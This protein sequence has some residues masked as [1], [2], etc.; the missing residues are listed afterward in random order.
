MYLSLLTIIRIY[1]HPYLV[2]WLVLPHNNPD[3]FNFLTCIRTL[4]LSTMIRISPIQ[5]STYPLTCYSSQWS[6]SIYFSSVPCLRTCISHDPNL[7]LQPKD[8]FLLTTIRIYFHPYLVY[9]LVSPNNNP[10]MSC[11]A[12]PCLL[13]CPSWQWSGSHLFSLTLSIDLSL[14]TMILRSLT[15]SIDLSLLTMIRISSS[16]SSGG[17]SLCFRFFSSFFRFSSLH[18]KTH[19]KRNKMKINQSEE[20]TFLPDT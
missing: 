10:Y 11:A 7:S 16:S 18:R 19:S 6:R 14:L 15:L 4:Y 1:F 17:S 20:E 12:L 8:L 13:T 3:P 5:P 2:H 9:G